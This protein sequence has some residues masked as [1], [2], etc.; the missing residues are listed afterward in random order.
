MN[1]L[2]TLFVTLLFVSLT[3]LQLGAQSGERDINEIVK[4]IDSA[5][6][7]YNYQ[8]AIILVDEGVSLLDSFLEQSPEDP[9]PFIKKRE[10]LLIIKSQ[11]LRK[12]FKVEKAIEALM[13]ISD[14][15]NPASNPKII[16]ELAECNKQLGNFSGALQFYNMLN[17][18][19]PNNL[20]F[21]MESISIKMKLE[22][23]MGVI[24]QA[25][26]VITRDTI[27]LMYRIIGDSYVNIGEVDSAYVYYKTGLKISPGD[28]YTVIKFARLM[29]AEKRLEELLSVLE[30]YIQEYGENPEV[31]QAYGVALHAN[32]DYEDSDEVFTKLLENGYDY[33][34]TYYYLGLNKY[35]MGKYSS[36]IIYLNEAH[37]I[38]PENIN[39][40]FYLGSAE[41]HG[42]DTRKGVERLTKGLDYFV[43]DSVNLHKFYLTISRGHNSLRE[44]K[45]ALANLDNAYKFSPSMSSYY[46]NKAII[47][48]RGRLTTEALNCY[49]QFTKELEQKSVD[50][51]DVLKLDPN[52][53]SAKNR[54]EQLEVDLFWNEK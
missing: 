30:S 53:K 42:G 16:A 7:S 48:D 1:T 35:Y 23:W 54:I 18:Y 6:V 21:T 27:P 15:I 41:V 50:N 12:L 10:D 49:R 24:D 2:K 20:Y 40:L 28:K 17:I 19:Q 29:L 36:S 14:T 51:P 5:I 11:S 25:K 39:L 9:L 43:Q 52:Y 31:M 22:D 46:Y 38:D 32:E 44:T 8:K 33:F 26:G 47:Y 4:S 45:E 34:A 13:A 3:P 37:S